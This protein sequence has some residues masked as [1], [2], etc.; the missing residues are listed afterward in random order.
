MHLPKYNYSMKKHKSCLILNQDYT[1]LTVISWKRAICLEI[2]GKEIIG[3]GIRVI[4]YYKDDHIES[5]GG[6]YFA[7]PAVAVTGRYIKRKRIITLKKRNLLIRDERK[8]QYCM[9]N[10]R[11]E[12]ATIDHVEPKS[13]FDPV[14]KAHTWENCVIACSRCNTKKANRNP[15]EAGMKLIK[16]P[17]E[18][19]PSSF[20]AGLSQW[21][22]I[23][24]E[25]KIYV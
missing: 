6:E 14:R 3:E 1:P 8:C 13:R 23:P 22:G 16:K 21:H 18:P 15:K 7:L 10:L 20:Y 4:E 25:W 12:T 19:D 5:A 9:C 2:I 17:V 24:E 11:P